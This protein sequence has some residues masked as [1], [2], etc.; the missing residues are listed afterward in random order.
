MCLI[1]WLEMF[2]V[3]PD[4]RI[5]GVYEVGS[6][7]YSAMA[8]TSL[9]RHFD[10]TTDGNCSTE[11]GLNIVQA[12]PLPESMVYDEEFCGFRM[13]VIQCVCRQG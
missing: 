13:K 12:R 3:H 8:S 4:F 1:L 9:A 2:F 11:T 10:R 6:V 7:T 5:L